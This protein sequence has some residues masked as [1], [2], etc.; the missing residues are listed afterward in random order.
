M[1]LAKAG[2][3]VQALCPSGHPFFET[4]VVQRY[5]RYRGMAPVKSF[6]NAI[7]A[8]KPDLVIPGDD[9]ATRHLHDVYHRLKSVGAS[10]IPA[11]IAK[12]LGSPEHWHLS[13]SRAAFISC[14]LEMGVRAPRM[15]VINNREDLD[16]WTTQS[17]LPAVLKADGTSGGDGV[18][19]VRTRPEAFDAFRSLHAPPLVARAVKRALLDR[20]STLVW[21]SLLR[22]RP[23]VSIQ[24]YVAGHEAT[25]TAACWQGKVLASLHFEVLQKSSPSGPASVLRRINNSD[26]TRATEI[27]VRRMN[28]SGLHG[29]DFMIEANTS[30]AYL[31]ETN[32]RAT[33]VGHLTLGSDHDLP[34]ALFA[35]A[36][37]TTLR[38]SAIVTENDVIALF[39]REWLRDPESSFLRSGFH[40]VP[41]DQPKLIASCVKHNRE[42]WLEQQVHPARS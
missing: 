1:G 28:L 32:P 16:H 8:A 10:D 9:L 17:G 24:Q 2:F 35:V 23:A 26:M 39:P 22:Q 12:S 27:M 33:Q 3:E 36:A 13:F 18:T 34:A 7:R 20:D 31:I 15:H 11:L 14:A 38:P 41:W 21:P 40:D 5:Y 25:S 4:N 29:F 6:I 37:G 19:I 42:Q 30:N